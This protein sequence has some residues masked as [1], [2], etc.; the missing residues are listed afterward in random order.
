[1]F[2]HRIIYC[3]DHSHFFYINLCSY[4]I[5]QVDVVYTTTDYVE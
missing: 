3:I 5:A 2:C 1:M 4:I